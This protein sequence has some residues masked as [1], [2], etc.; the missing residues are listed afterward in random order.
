[1]GFV[2]SSDMRLVTLPILQVVSFMESAI[3]GAVW[4]G[5]GVALPST[6]QI[7]RSGLAHLVPAGVSSRDHMALIHVLFLVPGFHRDLSC[8]LL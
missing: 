2:T 6:C 5:R 4:S 3:W 8:R 1:M 7:I